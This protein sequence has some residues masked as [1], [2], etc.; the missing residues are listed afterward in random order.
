MV[1]GLRH[2]YAI[3]Q[4]LLGEPVAHRL[5]A[6]AV[7]T[8]KGCTYMVLLQQLLLTPATVIARVTEVHASA[9]SHSILFS[10]SVI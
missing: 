2:S 4:Q 10:Y 7:T 5:H 6:A 3:Q 9:D 8:S 1:L